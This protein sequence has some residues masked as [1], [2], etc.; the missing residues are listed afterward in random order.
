MAGGA[1][2]IRAGSAYVEIGAD[3]R[4]FR[5][6]LDRATARF[7]AFEKR[8]KG[9]FGSR[10]PLADAFDIAVGGGA[11]AGVTM[12]A[13]VITEAADGMDE[14]VRKFQDGEIGVKE[15][16]GEIARSVPVLGSMVK[17]FD[18]IVGAVTGTTRETKRLEEQLRRVAEARKAFDVAQNKGLAELAKF[19]TRGIP[20][21]LPALDAAIAKQKQFATLG[22]AGAS[23]QA[24]ILTNLR[25]R[26]GAEILG[27][28][29]EKLTADS[30]IAKQARDA[31]AAE[32]ERQAGEELQRIRDDAA[33][34]VR[35]NKVK[36]AASVA[37]A[38]IG[39][40][41][42]DGAGFAN[43]KELQRKRLRNAIKAVEEEL[44]GAG[45]GGTIQ[46][47][48]ALYQPA[49]ENPVVSELRKTR[50]ALLEKMDALTDN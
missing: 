6:G 20:E 3:E 14:L 29:W 21:I 46:A 32:Q 26:I 17:M 1:G 49:T 4:G 11:V 44:R 19:D 15:F 8:L 5:A 23:E 36:L 9:G 37:E 7:E 39:Q 25:G 28:E 16:A 47:N 2:D 33:E 41:D 24:K 27:A 31:K 48:P 43:A 18:S 35:V 38:S 42:T 10:G 13:K 30:T 34:A 22:I 40:L 50:D 45:R 12:A